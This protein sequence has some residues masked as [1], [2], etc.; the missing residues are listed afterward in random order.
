M[1]T[2]KYNG[3]KERKSRNKN[4]RKIKRLECVAVLNPDKIIRSD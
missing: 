1:A 4:S 3:R 2:K